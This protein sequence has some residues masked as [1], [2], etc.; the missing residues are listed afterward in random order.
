MDTSVQILQ[1]H[2]LNFL[3]SLVNTYC[4]ITH[5]TSV[6]HSPCRKIQQQLTRSR[7]FERLTKCRQSSWGTGRAMTFQEKLIIRRCSLKFLRTI[8]S[9]VF[10]WLSVFSQKHTGFTQTPTNNVLPKLLIKASLR[11][12][13][14]VLFSQLNRE[15]KFPLKDSMYWWH[16]SNKQKLNL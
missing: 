6:P 16:S 11:I 2:Q 4:L 15:K 7:Y 12:Q 13:T 9:W 3:I 10:L 5:F 8:F 1:I 14:T